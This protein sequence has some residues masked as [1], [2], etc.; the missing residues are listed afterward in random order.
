MNLDLLLSPH[1]MIYRDLYVQ[2]YTYFKRIGYP[3]D[4]ANNSPAQRK[5]PRRSHGHCRRGS[6]RKL[7]PAP[8][9]DFQS[10]SSYAEGSARQRSLAKKRPRW[11]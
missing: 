3:K 1:P 10:L 6:D 2:L 11:L 9:Y 8:F 5:L 4:L 7:N